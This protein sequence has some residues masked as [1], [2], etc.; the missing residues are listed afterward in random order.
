[1]HFRRPKNLD[2]GSPTPTEAEPPA[3]GESKPIG[4]Q[5]EELIARLPERGERSERAVRRQAE[6]AITNSPE[7]YVT[8]GLK[9]DRSVPCPNCD[10][11]V[12][13]RTA[14]PW[15][16]LAA[17]EGRLEMFDQRKGEPALLLVSQVGDHFRAACT[18]CRRP[19]GVVSKRRWLRERI[20]AGLLRDA[21]FSEWQAA[22]R[23]DICRYLGPILERE[24]DV[25][26]LI[27]RGLA[28]P[29]CRKEFPSVDR[30]NDHRE[31]MHRT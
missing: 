22:A 15:E 28:C 3:P 27:E 20:E 21:A 18:E 4:L 2:S 8:F 23:A 29:D 30:C 1:M 12:V 26:G 11:A 25:D 19:I 31:T 9:A 6:Q 7:M 16:R 17:A 14:T 24:R 13:L 10:A 5:L